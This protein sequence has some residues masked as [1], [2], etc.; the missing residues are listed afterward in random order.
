MIKI[1]AAYSQPHSSDGVRIL[2][3]RIWPRGLKKSGTRIDEWRWDIAPT[4]ALRQWFRHDPRKWDEFKMRYRKELESREKIDELRKLADQARRQTITLLF[5]AR[6][7][8]HNTAVVLK[9]IL[10][11]LMEGR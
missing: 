8:Q 2:V 6:D 9:E 4:A 5:S 3:E 7:R 1:K 10:E 11:K